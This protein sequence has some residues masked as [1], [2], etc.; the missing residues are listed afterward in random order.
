MRDNTVCVRPCLNLTAS[1]DHRLIDGADA[2]R[3][4]Q[5]LKD[6]LQQFDESCL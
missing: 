4:L 5:A 3:F 6:R 2:G 1:Y